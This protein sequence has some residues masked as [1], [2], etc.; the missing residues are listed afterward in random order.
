MDL[1]TLEDRIGLPETS[2]LGV[3]DNE[4]ESILETSSTIGPNST[5]D[6]S[7]LTSQEDQLSAVPYPPLKDSLSDISDDEDD[8][9]EALELHTETGNREELD[10]LGRGHI[11][12]VVY[13]LLKV[14]LRS[15][16]S[17]LLKYAS[18]C[19][20]YRQYVQRTFP[21]VFQSV[22]TAMNAR[23]P[24][25][26]A[27]HLIDKFT[28]DVA[29]ERACSSKC[30]ACGKGISEQQLVSPHGR[31]R[32]QRS[33]NTDTFI[34]SLRLPKLCE[35]D[36]HNREFGAVSL[37]ALANRFVLPSTVV[38][39]CFRLRNLDS[40][41]SPRYY[42][43]SGYRAAIF[44]HGSLAA[45]QAR[46][47][48]G[49]RRRILIREALKAQLN[50]KIELDLL[51]YFIEHKDA[52]LVGFVLACRRR[53]ACRLRRLMEL[54]EQY[55]QIRGVAVAPFDPKSSEYELVG[56]DEESLLQLTSET[57][58]MFPDLKPILPLPMPQLYGPEVDFVF[59]GR[60][61]SLVAMHEQLKRSGMDRVATEV[62]AR[63]LQLHWHNRGMKSKTWEEAR[64]VALKYWL[65][66]TQKRKGNIPQ[67]WRPLIQGIMDA[68]PKK[69]VAKEKSTGKDLTQGRIL[70][71]T[72][73]AKRKGLD[74]KA[75]LPLFE[76]YA[77]GSKSNASAEEFVEELQRSRQAR[78]AEVTQGRLELNL[79]EEDPLHQAE[80]EFVEYGKD[81]PWKQ[82]QQK[83]VKGGTKRK[84]AGDSGFSS[85]KRGNRE[86]TTYDSR[87]R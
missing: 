77:R 51:Q 66:K 75:D 17:Y 29:H 37:V 82:V 59:Y 27:S 45:L 52:P 46:R 48:D 21:T 44:F 49:R 42:G 53:T 80:K 35:K 12:D 30:V 70:T 25:T 47:A 5:N 54:R 36:L 68:A 76:M 26:L 78:L 10:P 73:E 2:A 32:E 57:L 83:L 84:L 23:I 6:D 16:S 69:A 79:P 81:S 65:Q 9:I 41:S 7:F 4:S 87:R 56:S 67:S 85:S 31:A 50:G 28:F 43:A 15:D 11:E 72:R 64:A 19:R 33:A 1:S 63:R 20:C 38:E 24:V 62:G 39:H 58:T 74:H 18:I 40:Q 22:D 3:D 8:D 14:Y 61:D 13:L 71:L 34:R 86:Y 60:I 55:K